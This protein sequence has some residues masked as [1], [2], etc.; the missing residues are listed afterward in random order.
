MLESESVIQLP[1][2][3][4]IKILK[5][6]HLITTLSHLAKFRHTGYCN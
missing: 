5:P 6:A 1:C 4:K 2:F 3:S